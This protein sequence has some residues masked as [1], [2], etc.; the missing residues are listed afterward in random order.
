[1]K[2]LLLDELMGAETLVEKEFLIEFISVT[3]NTKTTLEE[4]KGRFKQV[5]HR[6]ESKTENYEGLLL[7]EE[8]EYFGKIRAKRKRSSLTN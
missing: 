7:P 8:I 5:I 3:N 6:I 2:R 4:K 1:M